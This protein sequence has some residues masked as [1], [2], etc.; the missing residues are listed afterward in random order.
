MA[1]P[2]T[3]V[4]YLEMVRIL[5][6]C[7]DNVNEACRV[8]LERFGVR[9]SNRTMLGVT[10]R[11]REYG[12]F[13]PPIAVDH[14]ANINARHLE[15]QERILNYAFE[16]PTTSTRIMARLFGCSHVFVWQV[17][18]DEGL[19]PYHYRRCQELNPLDYQPR[20]R[21]CHWLLANRNLDI[22]WTDECTFTRIGLFNQH[23]RHM[24]AYENPHLMEVD[25]FQHRFALNVW[26][27]M[28]RGRIFGPIFLPRLNGAV[29]LDFLRNNLQLLIANWLYEEDLPLQRAREFFYQHDGAPA[30]F[31]INVR[32]YLDEEFGERW[33]GRA[34]PVQWPARS[35]DLTPLDFFLWGRVK[36]LVYDDGNG[37]N[38]IIELR[39]KIIA[40]FQTVKND[41]EVL[42][43]VHRHTIVRAV[44]CIREGGRH[45][46][47]LL[48]GKGGNRKGSNR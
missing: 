47:S 10:Q 42:N 43:S 9:V 37:P 7:N 36:A 26:A 39:Q 23:N 32:R 5:A 30:H 8:Y 16:H 48:K 29:Y 34:G 4:Q 40:A 19:H 38:N 24:W 11:L 25:N 13:R 6:V 44:Y 35:P 12:N 20:V 22:L 2:F 15:L 14:G 28:I 17:L 21:F 3:N 46:E 1:F 27:G 41:R 45:F 33:I 18:R 31:E